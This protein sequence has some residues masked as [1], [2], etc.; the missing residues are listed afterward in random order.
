MTLY[1]IGLE[2]AK[3]AEP[4]RRE[5]R[6]LRKRLKELTDPEE[7]WRTKQR[8]QALTPILT[9]CNRLRDYCERYYE[10][11]YFI[12]NGPFGRGHKCGAE[13]GA[14]ASHAGT[15]CSIEQ[16]AD[17]TPAGSGDG[18]LLERA[19]IC[20]GRGTKRRKQVDCFKELLSGT[21][22]A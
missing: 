19:H 9:D 1:E 20:G 14:R 18:V 13:T 7:I 5:L 6:E 15:P 4:I 8:I 2:Y 11:G 16:R 10:R 22:K 3:S 21:R 12:G 17:R